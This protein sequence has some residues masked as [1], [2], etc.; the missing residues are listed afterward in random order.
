MHIS[1]RRC[2]HDLRSAKAKDLQAKQ[3]CNGGYPKAHQVAAAKVFELHEI[4]NWPKL[5]QMEESRPRSRE[6]DF[7][8]FSTQT[9]R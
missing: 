4:H 1:S 9:Q 6:K 3:Y 7:M 2:Y 8:S 5:S